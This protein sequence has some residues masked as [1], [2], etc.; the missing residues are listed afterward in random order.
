M[1]SADP[2]SWF[3]P[4]RVDNLLPPYDAQCSV[5]RIT[6]AA[7]HDGLLTI[8]GSSASAN[9]GASSGPRPSTEWGGP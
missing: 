2:G 1:A 8:A 9:Q 6:M 4:S 3:L 5:S 7:E